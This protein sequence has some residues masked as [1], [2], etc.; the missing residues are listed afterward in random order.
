M[1]ADRNEVEPAGDQEDDGLDGV[2]AGD[3]ACAAL[4]GL[5]QAVEG[6]EQAVG[7]AGSRPGHD[8]FEVRTKLIGRLAPMRLEGINLRGVFRFPLQRYTQQILPSQAATK[9]SVVS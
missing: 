6:F 7:L 1:R 4:R 5:K 3:A 2:E 8:A 9:T